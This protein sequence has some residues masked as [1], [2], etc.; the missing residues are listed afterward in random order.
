MA[1]YR[2]PVYCTP[3][4]VFDVMLMYDSDEDK[5]M[6]ASNISS[7]DSNWLERAIVQQ[8]DLFE[9][10]T[11]RYYIERSAPQMVRDYDTLW[12]NINTTRL[13]A[14]MHGSISVPLIA[15]VKPWDVSKD[16]LEF[17]TA[18]ATWIDVSDQENVK[19]TIDYS[20]GKLRI[21]TNLPTRDGGIRIK[22]RYGI[23]T[24]NIPYD[25]RRAVALGTAMHVAA[26]DWYRVRIGSG[27]D[28]G[29]KIQSTIQLWKKEYD[30][31]VSINGMPSR[32]YSLYG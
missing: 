10:R 16:K 12:R 18:P 23:G 28:L 17:R 1:E 14:N 8:E 5:I 20:I 26:T 25:C 15:P 9:N 32:V 6:D 27:G 3:Q 13:M 19:W 2:E 21:L 11:R 4:D 29:N 24:D 30:E 31:I 7:P 22:Y